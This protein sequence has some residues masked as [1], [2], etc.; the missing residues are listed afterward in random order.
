MCIRRKRLP[1]CYDG[2]CLMHAWMPGWLWKRDLVRGAHALLQVRVHVTCKTVIECFVRSL[3][4][5]L[6]VETAVAATKLSEKEE[7]PLQ[8]HSGS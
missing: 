1:I 6:E 3:D 8:R 5:N 7:S 2:R 4:E